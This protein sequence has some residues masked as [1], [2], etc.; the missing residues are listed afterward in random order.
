[1]QKPGPWWKRCARLPAQLLL[2][3]EDPPGT[4]IRAGEDLDL[5]LR[6]LPLVCGCSLGAGA[7]LLACS[8]QVA[9][10]RQWLL[11]AVLLAALGALA[12]LLGE[13]LWLRGENAPVRLRL[14]TAGEVLVYCR[15][16]RVDRVHLRPQS[17]RVGGGLLLVLRG[18]R[19]YHLCLG[20][21][22][23]APA[24]LAGLHRRMGRGPTGIPGLR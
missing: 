8:A 24:T 2:Q 23:L 5:P 6:P 9:V 10:Q 16:G 18:T 7:A 20:S 3:F 14:T 1:M 21:G 17:L 19:S 22:N 12:V 11:A 15:N 4:V 13:V